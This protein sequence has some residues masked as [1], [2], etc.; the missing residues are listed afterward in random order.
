MYAGIVCLAFPTYDYSQLHAGIACLASLAYDWMTACWDSLSILL[1]AGI[2]CLAFLDYD[3]A[4][5]KVCFNPFGVSSYYG[6]AQTQN[7]MNMDSQYFPLY[8]Y[9]H[10]FIAVIKY[11]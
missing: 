5:T 3:W 10:A 2:A 9:E 4:I 6:I 11:Y 1:H 7:R 8:T